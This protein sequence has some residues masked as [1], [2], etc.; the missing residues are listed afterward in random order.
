MNQT[1]RVLIAGET[2]IMHTIHQKGFDSFTTTEYG[3]GI[4]WLKAALEAG[5]IGVE[6]LP[7]HA[8]PTQFPTD[9]ETLR[10][11]D[12]VVL[13]DIGANSLLLHPDTF[14]RSRATPNRLQLL[15]DYVA[16]GGGLVMVGGYLSF[17]GID[18]KARYGGTPVED[19]L[20]VTMVQGD[21][22]VEVPEG[23]AANVRD[24]NHPIVAG[25]PRT[26]PPV[27]GYS[28]VRTRPEAATVAVLGDDPLLAAWDFHQGRA[29]AF[30]S[31]CSTH[32]CPPEFLAWDGYTRLWQQIIRWAARSESRD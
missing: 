3:E 10:S 26:W 21:D 8:A 4:G 13:S 19:A 16:G 32:W 25:L 17:S 6:H 20:P 9:L 11:Y 7:N 23:S 27:L 24:A 29:V 1:P 2:W 30:T 15:R 18:G 5:G 14:V 28:R 31:D 22:R 12:V